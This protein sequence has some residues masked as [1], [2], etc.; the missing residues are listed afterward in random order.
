[1]LPWRR[2]PGTPAQPDADTGWRLACPSRDSSLPLPMMPLRPFRLSRP[3][4]CTRFCPP[5]PLSWNHSLQQKP[6]HSVGNPN[7]PDALF[8]LLSTVNQHNKL[9][10]DLRPL[11][12][13]SCLFP[14]HLPGGGGEAMVRFSPALYRYFIYFMLLLFFF[15]G[16]I[17]LRRNTGELNR[18]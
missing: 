5:P 7:L 17:D 9:K 11:S 2:W 1:M 8:L 15:I 16:T 13:T 12:L 3:H 14:S 10:S 4:L 6:D 18:P